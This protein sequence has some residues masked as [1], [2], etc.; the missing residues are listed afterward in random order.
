MSALT[1]LFK[2][3]LHSSL[4]WQI[5]A[6][7]V[8]GEARE[9]NEDS[10]GFASKAGTGF[11]V[12]A[13]GVGGHQAGEVASRFVCDSLLDWFAS[14]AISGDAQADSTLLHDALADINTALHQQALRHSA[15]AGM[16]STVSVVMQSRRHAVVIWAGDSRIYYLRQGKLSQLSMDHSIVEENVRLG[17]LA[18][19]EVAQHPMGHIITSSIGNKERIPHL[20]SLVLPLKAGDSLLLVSDGVSDALTSEQI[21]HYLPEG[22]KALIAAAKAAHSTDDCSAIVIRVR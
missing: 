11:A 17:I 20:G 14:A 18:R 2:Q 7:S 4:E 10:V 3:L 5:E 8:T 12:L 16:A 21:M 13:D 22:P 1:N 15:Q 6:V 19:D 9:H